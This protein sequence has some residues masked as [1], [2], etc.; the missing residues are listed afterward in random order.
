MVAGQEP[1][2][3]ESTVNKKNLNAKMEQT[4]VGVPPAII[5]INPR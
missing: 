5:R 2:K 1:R 4:Q 3:I